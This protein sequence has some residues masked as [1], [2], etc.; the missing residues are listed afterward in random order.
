METLLDLLE[1]SARRYTDR[2]ALGL[3][4]DDGTTFHWSYSEVLRRSRLA[5]WRLKA[6]GLQPGDRVLTWSPSTPSLPAAYYGAMY[7]R[8]IYVPLD[9]RMSPTAI[10]NIIEAS[11]A[12]RLLLGTGR[13]A[14]DPREFGLEI[15]PDLDHRRPVRG[16]RRHVPRGL[17]CPGA[18]LGASPPGRDLPARVHQRDDRN[19]EGRDARP[20]QLARRRDVLPRDREADGAPDG[21]AAPALAQPR[22]AGRRCSMRWTWAPTSCTCAAGTRGSSSTACASTA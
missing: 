15:V 12:V 8:L 13:D 3:R 1:D 14:P 10:T 4:R 19:P 22:A 5:A 20:L 11:G 18:G 6:L 2:N 17:G 21:L 7:A 16:T 9:S